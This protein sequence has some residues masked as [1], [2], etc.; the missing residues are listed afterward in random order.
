MIVFI[1]TLH[2]QLVT[3][4]NTVLSLI[5][6]L[7]KSLGHAKSSQSSLVIFWQRIYNNLPLT[8]AHYKVF[9][10]QLNPFLAI[11]LPTAKSGDSLNSISQLPDILVI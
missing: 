2:I 1:E 10:A 3:T 9:F 7:Y 11:I 4:S 6:I 5:Y 8:A